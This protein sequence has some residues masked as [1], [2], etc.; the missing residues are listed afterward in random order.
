MSDSDFDTTLSISRG[1]ERVYDTIQSEVP[2]VLL[3]A[4]KLALWNTIEEFYTQSTLLR[5]QVYWRMAPGVRSVTINP[6]ADYRRVIWILDYSGLRESKIEPPSTIHDLT[7]PVPQTE[8]AGQALV[9]LAPNSFEAAVDCDG[10]FSALWSTWFETIL[11][12]TKQRLF[13]QPEKPYTNPTLAAFNAR[14]FLRGKLQAKDYT[15][16]RYSAARPIQ[17]PYFAR[18]HQ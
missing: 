5:E 15:R 1:A 2:G 17:F 13:A 4:I 7:F 10:M 3:P 12:G 16:R 8:R 14:M 9:A 18:G 6:F 11:A